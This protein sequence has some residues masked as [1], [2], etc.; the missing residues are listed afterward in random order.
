MRKLAKSYSVQGDK[1]TKLNLEQIKSQTKNLV[2]E[3]PVPPKSNL[4]EL[5]SYFKRSSGLFNAWI[6]CIMH[7]T[8][9]K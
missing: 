3:L 6:P 5:K 4:E 1:Y 7:L 9:D 8:K 2:Q